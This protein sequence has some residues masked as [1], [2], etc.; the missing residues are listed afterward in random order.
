M[1]KIFLNPKLY[2]KDVDQK[3][4]RDG[5]GDGLVVAGEMNPNVVAVCADLTESTRTLKFAERWPER[6]IE[7]GV[8]EQNLATVGAGLAGAG[9]IPFITSY[10]TFSP[11]RN[12]E[13]IRTTIC[14]NDQPVKIIGS[15]AGI[16]VGPDGAT[17]QAME[18]IAIMRALPNMVVMAPCDAI[19]AKKATVAALNHPGPVYIRLGREKTPVVTTEKTPFRLGAGQIFTDGSDLTI[20]ATGS[21]VY[22]ALIAAKDLAKSKVKARVISLATIKPLD[23]KLIIDSAKKTNAIVTCEEHQVH[24]GLGGAVSE[25]LAGKYPVPIEFVGMMDQFGES[26]PPQELLEKFGMKAKNIVEAAKTVLR[27]KTKSKSK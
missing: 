3:P 18:D 21:M 20:I 23:E 7:V 10:A 27:R 8:A 26:G 25:L 6:Y 15:H 24:G 4:I 5:Y 16:S 13:Q 1:N 11:G 19:E 12:W 9:K 22:E 14:Y 17:H 2:S